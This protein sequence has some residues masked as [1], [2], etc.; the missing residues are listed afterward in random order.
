MLKNLCAL[1]VLAAGVTF[2]SGCEKET[3]ACESSYENWQGYT[4]YTC[5]QNEESD[6][7]EGSREHFWKDK[8]CSDLGYDYYNTNNKS[9]QID[10]QNNGIPGPYGYWG[11][12]S[13]SGG[14]GSGGSC[15]ASGYKGPNFDIQVDSQCKTAY[16]YK[17]QGNTQGQNAACAVYKQWQQDDPSIPNCPYCN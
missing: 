8:S 5:E 1:I 6:M 4:L 11:D 17:C 14:S 3:G 10:A 16:F 15:D 12:G 7:C 9:Y 2:F 13:A